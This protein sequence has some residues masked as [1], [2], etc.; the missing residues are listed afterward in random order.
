MKFENTPGG[1][2]VAELRQITRE[3]IVVPN[4]C[5]PAEMHDNV[6]GGRTLARLEELCDK[7]DGITEHTKK[8]AIKARNI[9]K[10]RK[11]FEEKAQ[12]HTHRGG[13]DFVDLESEFDYSDN[14]CDDLQLTK[15]MQALVG[16][17]VN[18]GLIDADD[19]L[20]D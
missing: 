1:K 16:G 9:E 4:S 11:Q 5:L 10:L 18:G 6:R 19:L 3:M 8:Q 15:N 7:R 2:L 14:E 12:F 13:T 17:M 20:E